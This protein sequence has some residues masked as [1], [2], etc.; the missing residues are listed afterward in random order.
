MELGLV[1][2]GEHLGEVQR[3]RKEYNQIY[4]MKNFFLQS[5]LSKD[6]YFYVKTP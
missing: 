4:Y 5:H 3:D 1:G 2:S 6:F